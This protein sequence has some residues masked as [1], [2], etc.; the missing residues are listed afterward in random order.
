MDTE[1]RG[2]TIKLRSLWRPDVKKV[3]STGL[4]RVHGLRCPKCHQLGRTSTI[5]PMPSA[6]GASSATNNLL[7]LARMVGLPVVIDTAQFRVRASSAK[8]MTLAGY[9]P[10]SDVSALRIMVGVWRSRASCILLRTIS[11]SRIDRA[12][13]LA[14]RAIQL[15]PVHPSPRSPTMTKSNL[16]EHHAPARNHAQRRR[17]TGKIDQLALAMISL[18]VLNCSVNDA[19]APLD[20][21][22]ATGQSGFGAGAAESYGLALGSYSG[23]TVFSNGPNPNDPSHYEP[24]GPYGYQYECVEFVNRFYRQAL[25]HQGYTC[26]SGNMRGCGN[27]KDYFGNAK[28][29]NLQPFANGGAEPPRV[30]DILAMG[31]GRPDKNGQTYGHVAIIR[32][33]TPNP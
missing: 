14:A 27:G 13:C 24:Y 26:G 2:F 8:L 12:V 19:I 33:V 28:A 32:D 1:A 30:N 3:S 25:D 22:D 4:D 29:L 7:L 31:G 9:I 15:Q 17:N 5:G 23:V 10:T 6:I 20:Q 16:A 11:S 21:G 18:A